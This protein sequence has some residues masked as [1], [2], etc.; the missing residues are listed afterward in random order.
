MTYSIK[1][2]H[3]SSPTCSPDRAET[4]GLHALPCNA[5]TQALKVQNSSNSVSLP[6]YIW[7]QPA[8]HAFFICLILF[9]RTCC[10]IRGNWMIVMIL[11]EVLEPIHLLKII[12]NFCAIIWDS[13]PCTDVRITFCI[14]SKHD[15]MKVMF[16]PNCKHFLEYL[17]AQFWARLMYSW[18]WS[19]TPRH[20]FQ[21]VT[22]LSTELTIL[23]RIS[24]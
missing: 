1:L 11:K 19:P 3:H 15:L 2:C 23:I 9:K 14:G 5:L 12:L 6:F 17:L 22:A 7:S 24:A 16:F 20:F 8:T 18:I 10:K 21:L 13:K 4:S